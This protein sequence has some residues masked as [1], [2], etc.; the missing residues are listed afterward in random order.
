[1]RVEAA[2]AGMDMDVKGSHDGFLMSLA[3]SSEARWFVSDLSTR[4]EISQLKTQLNVK[5]T[6]A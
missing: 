4:T 2:R 6:L 3:R 5:K 1:M